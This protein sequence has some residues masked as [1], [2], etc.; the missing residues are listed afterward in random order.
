MVIRFKLT[1]E[2]SFKYKSASDVGGLGP[3]RIIDPLLRGVDRAFERYDRSRD[4][5]NT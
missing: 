1:R 5:V 4:N 3:A 2:G